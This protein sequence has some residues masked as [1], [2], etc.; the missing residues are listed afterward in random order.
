MRP[1]QHLSLPVHHLNHRANRRSIHLDNRLISHPISHPS[2]HLLS[3]SVSLLISHL[4]SHPTNHRISH[5]ISHRSLQINRHLLLQVSPLELLPNNLI[6]VQPCNQLRSHIYLR[7][8]N[9]SSSH[10]IS[11]RI[12][13]P[14]SHP[15]SHRSLQNSLHHSHQFNPLELLPNNLICVQPYNQLCSH[16]CFQLCSPLCVLRTNQQCH[17]RDNPRHSHLSLHHS[18]QYNPLYSLLFSLPFSRNLNLVCSHPDNHY[19][20]HRSN[21]PSNRLLSL[22]INHIGDQRNNHHCN[23]IPNL[24]INQ[25][26]SQ[27]SNHLCSHCAIHLCSRSVNLPHNPPSSLQSNHQHNRL[28]NLRSTLPNSQQSSRVCSLYLFR[29][30]I[31]LIHHQKNRGYSPASNRHDNQRGIQ[32]LNLQS[33]LPINLQVSRVNNHYYCHHHF[34]LASRRS[35][36]LRN[37]LTYHQ[38]SQMRNPRI[39]PLCSLRIVLLLNQSWNHHSNHYNIRPFNRNVDQPHNRASIHPCYRR[40]SLRYSP[41]CNLLLIR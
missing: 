1:I 24:P 12:G 31:P 16:I 39:S 26:I 32:H 36:R 18:Q 11:H 33:T 4:I 2:N 9:H 14:S 37:L 34:Q 40:Q 23:Q 41:S 30:P 35:N 10:P 3:H 22:A 13:H 7:L 29:R 5:R 15:V 25:H 21:H 6:C 38:G 28:L 20:I 19:C 8:C 27:R 17:Q